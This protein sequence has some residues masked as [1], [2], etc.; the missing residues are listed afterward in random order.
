MVYLVEAIVLGA[1]AMWMAGLWRFKQAGPVAGFA[2]LYLGFPSAA[3]GYQAFA[4]HAAMLEPAQWAAVA[5]NC[6]LTAGLIERTR[7]DDN[8]VLRAMILAERER[9]AAELRKRAYDLA[10]MLVD[11]APG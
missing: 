2:A 6:V 5:V 1:A 9:V 3:L 10:G 7:D 11:D 8:P 4:G